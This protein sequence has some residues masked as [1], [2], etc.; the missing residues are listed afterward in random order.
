MEFWNFKYRISGERQANLEVP[1]ELKIV[2]GVRIVKKRRE[3][4]Y[5]VLSQTPTHPHLARLPG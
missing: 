3:K 2:S 1:K 5:V 4:H